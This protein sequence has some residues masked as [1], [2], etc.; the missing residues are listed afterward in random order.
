VTPPHVPRPLLLLDYDGTLAPIVDDPSAAVPHPRVPA[1]L[2]A[3]D[4]DHEVRVITGRDL[5]SLAALLSVP[6]RA[7]G[8]HG[9]QAG[10]LGGE[11]ELHVSADART[12]LGRMR[13][14]LPDIAGLRVE[15]KG[16]MFAL[17]FRGVPEPMAI[18]D[19]LAGWLEGAPSSL[20]PVWG[21]MVLELRPAGTD[22]GSVARGL[23]AS[24]PDLTPVY[25]GDDTTDEDAF[26]A[27]RED[28]RA[29]TIKVGPG[30]TAAKHRLATV[31][32]VVIYLAG[33]LTR[34]LPSV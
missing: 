11:S 19:A 9:A 22:K 17:H 20:T 7:V 2:R 15:E 6:V 31:E 21:K 5:A 8:L 24:L 30:E 10:R 25:L 28:P 14:A 27:L 18:R 1:L 34:P 4:A 16:P 32:H 26:R 12:A 33:Y 3:L 13:A 23:A 29:V